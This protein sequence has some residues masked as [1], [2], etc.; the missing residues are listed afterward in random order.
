MGRPASE[1]VA[2]MEQIGPD[3]RTAKEGRRRLRLPVPFPTGR[4]GIAFRRSRSTRWLQ[5]GARGGE[6]GRRGSDA[7]PGARRRCD[8]TLGKMAT[9]RP[10]ASSTPAGAGDRGRGP[11]PTGRSRIARP[12]ILRSTCGYNPRPRWGENKTGRR[13]FRLRPGG[14]WHAATGSQRRTATGRPGKAKPVETK[15]PSAP[16][17]GAEAECPE[18]VGSTGKR[19]W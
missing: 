3:R 7:R 6:I 4:V 14:A 8:L 15:I 16:P 2:K 5:S 10:F 19:I 1:F 18:N 12:A 11:F 9:N 17:A 13:C